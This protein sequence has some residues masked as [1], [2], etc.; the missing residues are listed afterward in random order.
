[1]IKTEKIE[2]RLFTEEGVELKNSIIGYR[3]DHLN[4]GITLD[5][6]MFQKRTETLTDDCFVKIS[7]ITIL[8]SCQRDTVTNKRFPKLRKIGKTFNPVKYGRAQLAKI[9]G[10]PNLYIYDGL[11]RTTAAYCLG[12]KEIPCEITTFKSE[13]EVLIEFFE[14]HENEEKLSGWTKVHT[15]YHAPVEMQIGY[16]KNHY[17][18]TVDIYRVLEKTGCVYDRLKAAKGKPKPSVESG[19]T[20]FRECIT[21]KW[22]GNGS[23]KAGERESY[24]LIKALQMINKLWIDHDRYNVHANLLAAIVYYATDGGY[25]VVTP[26][27]LQKG[28]GED[29]K[30]INKR[31]QKLDDRLCKIAPNDILITQD[32]FWAQILHGA[33]LM[34][35][36]VAEAGAAK[37]KSFCRGNHRD[38]YNQIITNHRAKYGIKY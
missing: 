11:G 15:V 35:K 9:E 12:I 17:K 7:D 24:A 30:Q 4:N 20:R 37:I 21:Q 3:K 1:M 38:K 25:H 29:I 19:L 18:Q 13:A 22:S 8:K 36:K 27:A 2:E 5:K 32:E 10:D 26:S 6:E 14:Q 28:D 33:D 31:L 34:N 23:I 16:F